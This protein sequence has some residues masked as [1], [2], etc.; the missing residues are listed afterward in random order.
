MARG[1]VIHMDEVLGWMSLLEGPDDV[2]HNFISL[3]GDGHFA[4]DDHQGDLK[5]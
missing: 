3:L 4:F 5:S 1:V 2:K